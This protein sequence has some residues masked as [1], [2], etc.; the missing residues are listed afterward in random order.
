M[1]TASH[2]RRLRAKP[3]SDRA[4]AMAQRTIIPMHHPPKARGGG[5]AATTWTS[6]RACFLRHQ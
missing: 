3:K 4:S 1:G 2:V 5:G 6:P